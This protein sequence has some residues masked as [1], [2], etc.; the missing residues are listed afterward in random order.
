VACPFFEPVQPLG[1]E[2]WLH[3]P[4]FPLGECYRGRC[5]AT[6]ERFEPPESAQDE[7]CNCGYAR[8]RCDRFPAES[9]D[10]VRFSVAYED[11][12]HIRI[13]YIFERRHAPETYGVIEYSKPLARL[14]SELDSRLFALAIAF[15]RSHLRNSVL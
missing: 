3:A 11:D 2:Q 14:D 5:R 13:I 1:R 10:A 8:G 4:R 9:A 7:L 15:I 6:S 12:Q